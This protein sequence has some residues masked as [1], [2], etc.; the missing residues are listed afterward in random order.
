MLLHKHNSRDRL[1]KAPKDTE[2]TFDLS[3]HQERRIVLL[4][5]TLLLLKLVTFMSAVEA[6]SSSADVAKEPT[7]QAGIC[8][9]LI[10]AVL[11]ES[12]DVVDPQKAQQLAAVFKSKGTLVVALAA[13]NYN[14]EGKKD[15]ARNAFL[16]LRCLVSL[17]SADTAENIATLLRL[18]GLKRISGLLCP[19]PCA[20]VAPAED[21]VQ[22]WRLY[23]PVSIVSDCENPELVPQM[24]FMA[25]VAQLLVDLFK[26]SAGQSGSTLRD[27]CPSSPAQVSDTLETRSQDADIRAQGATPAAPRSDLSARSVSPSMATESWATPTAAVWQDK[28]TIALR[29]LSTLHWLSKPGQLQ[30][31]TAE[32]PD[33]SRSATENFQLCTAAHQAVGEALLRL[34][35]CCLAGHLLDPS[36]GVGAFIR[37]GLSPLMHDWSS[38]GDTA[39]GLTFSILG[40]MLLR[41]ACDHEELLAY[42]Q[43]VL[44][45]ADKVVQP[46]QAALIWQLIVDS[47]GSSWSSQ[48][49]FEACLARLATHH[50]DMAASK[51]RESGTK[52][53]EPAPRGA[54]AG[55]RLMSQGTLM[56]I[57]DHLQVAVVRPLPW[58]STECISLARVLQQMAHLLKQQP[59]YDSSVQQ[60]A[61]R[62]VGMNLVKLW[63]ASDRRGLQQQLV[64]GGLL[65][66]QL[67]ERQSFDCT[68]NADKEQA[69]CLLPCHT[70]DHDFGQL[71]YAPYMHFLVVGAG[72]L[73]DKSTQGKQQ[74]ALVLHMLPCVELVA[75]MRP[76]PDLPSFS[77][78]PPPRVRGRLVPAGLPLLVKLN[79]AGIKDLAEPVVQCIKHMSEHLGWGKIFSEAQ[80]SG[81]RQARVELTRN[82]GCIYRA[83]GLPRNTLDDI[84]LI[85]HPM[86]KGA[87]AHDSASVAAAELVAEEEQAATKAAAKKAKKLRQKLKQLFCCPLTKVTMV[88]PTIA[89][90]GHTYERSAIQDWLTRS[91]MSPVTGLFWGR[92]T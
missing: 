70:A 28:S 78:A 86:L 45:S 77:M 43:G 5:S 39:K 48:F 74:A 3:A 23:D 89:A 46:E 10:A 61:E 35:H 33:P 55:S 19:I 38:R 67:A 22:V 44:E 51:A 7:D 85:F 4:Q 25:R 54:E 15:K 50:W 75:C 66:T 52:A 31:L 76:D 79:E 17:P 53:R 32:V 49:T 30:K 14:G 26:A 27:H 87:P 82:I 90:D 8:C 80:R 40:P 68:G 84:L 37:R 72:K 60:L 13:L 18:Q 24:K 11:L 69:E 21:M 2:L 12:S 91:R 71:L 81:D 36:L 62:I 56:A 83:Q 1:D 47:V 59:L 20:L 88:D 41:L 73:L 65:F 29:A 92:M 57:C 58:K 64:L 16:V 9:R 42:E 6:K 34:L 63:D